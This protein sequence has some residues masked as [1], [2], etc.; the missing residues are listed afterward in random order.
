MRRQERVRRGHGRRDRGDVPAGGRVQ[1]R[2]ELLRREEV[3]DVRRDPL[4][5]QDRHA[6]E[7][8]RDVDALRAAGRAQL[9]RQQRR[10]VVRAEQP[11]Q[12]PG[13][14]RQCA[15][16]RWRRRAGDRD[17]NRGTGATG[18]SRVD[19]RVGR[20]VVD[21]LRAALERPCTGRSSS[22]R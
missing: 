18:R 12:L 8:R 13:E 4:L 15:L 20:R 17:R 19:R 6:L 14:R 16:R 7:R 5:E 22:C 21:R 2:R 11:D 1:L 10:E 3:D 9:L